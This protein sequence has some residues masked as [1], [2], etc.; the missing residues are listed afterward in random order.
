MIINNHKH[1]VNKLYALYVYF[2]AC[3]NK[4]YPVQRTYDNKQLSMI[5]HTAAFF[6]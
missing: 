6:E 2:P 4:P 1:R 5:S 3:S